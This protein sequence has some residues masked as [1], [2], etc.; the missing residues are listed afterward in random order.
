MWQTK[1]EPQQH[2]HPAHFSSSS[3][4]SQGSLWIPLFNNFQITHLNAFTEPIPVVQ[5]SFTEQVQYHQIP[6]IL[7]FAYSSRFMMLC[8]CGQ[9]SYFLVLLP[10]FKRGIENV[11]IYPTT[12]K[13]HKGKQYFLIEVEKFSSNMDV[14]SAHSPKMSL[15]GFLLP[16]EV[17][18]MTLKD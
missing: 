1:R 2:S 5:S 12:W 18:K 13:S 4:N 9:A 15:P 7:N 16:E 17:L 6:A 14:G 11:V 10:S 8:I 3:Y